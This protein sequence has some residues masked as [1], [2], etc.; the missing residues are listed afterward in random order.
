MKYRNSVLGFIAAVSLTL[1]DGDAAHA[2]GHGSRKTC[3]LTPE[4]SSVIALVRA[5]SR[6]PTRCSSRVRARLTPDGDSP[7]ALGGARDSPC[8]DHGDKHGDP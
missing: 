7:S 5:K 4:I 2:Q 8:L 1:R 6:A 3:R